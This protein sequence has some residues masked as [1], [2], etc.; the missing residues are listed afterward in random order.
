MDTC[1]LSSRQVQRDLKRHSHYQ[2]EQFLGIQL[3]SHTFLWIY[4]PSQDMEDRPQLFSF[5][6]QSITLIVHNRTKQRVTCVLVWAPKQDKAF[7]S[8]STGKHIYRLQ[9]NPTVLSP[10][11]SRPALKWHNIRQRQPPPKSPLAVTALR[12]ETE[13][14]RTLWNKERKNQRKTSNSNLFKRVYVVTFKHLSLL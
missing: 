4:S 9:T 12:E 3:V 8:G 5:K 7:R 11:Q 14:Q 6:S 1:V 13:E 10:W 2:L